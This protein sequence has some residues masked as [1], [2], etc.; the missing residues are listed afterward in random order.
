MIRDG[1]ITK[2]AAFRMYQQMVAV[3]TDAGEVING[4]TDF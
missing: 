1:A 4:P 3:G 2:K